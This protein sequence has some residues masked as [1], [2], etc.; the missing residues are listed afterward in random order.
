MAEGGS[1]AACEYRRAG[2]FLRC[3]GR[4]ANGVHA[5]VDAVQAAGTDP[6]RDCS[7]ADSE[8]E[9]L[10]ASDV[11]IPLSGQ[12]RHRRIERGGRNCRI[13]M[14]S[15]QAL[16]HRAPDRRIEALERPMFAECCDD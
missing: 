5:V 12:L 8:L 13:A 16:G 6:P 15:S 1:G 7:V 2:A 14:V 9:E 4:A 11:A 3:H 10:V